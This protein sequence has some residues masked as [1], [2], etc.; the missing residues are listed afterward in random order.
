MGDDASLSLALTFAHC[1][2]SSS[3]RQH[4]LAILTHDVNIIL[5]SWRDEKLTLETSELHIYWRMY[6]NSQ[7]LYQEIV[8]MN[9]PL[10]D[11]MPYIDD[12]LEYFD[13]LRPL[14]K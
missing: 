6:K 14:H 9:L 10:M 8:G 4:K 13:A 1:Q 11:I 2:I 3:A 12:Y 7:E 5:S